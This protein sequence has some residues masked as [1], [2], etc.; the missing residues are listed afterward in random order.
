VHCVVHC[1]GHR[2]GRDARR[3]RTRSQ[4]VALVQ[5]EYAHA[6]APEPLRRI[7][8]CERMVVGQTEDGDDAFEAWAI[9]R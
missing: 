8:S 3:G 9:A 4:L 2:V 1:V 5:R 6:D 7:Q